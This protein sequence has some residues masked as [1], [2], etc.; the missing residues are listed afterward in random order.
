MIGNK[1]YIFGGQKEDGSLCS[2]DV[3]AVALPSDQPEYTEYA[4][5]PAVDVK[6]PIRTDHAACALN[7]S[8]VVNGGQN[9]Q[10][11]ALDEELGIWLWDRETAKWSRVNADGKTPESRYSHWIFPG[12][13][14]D[15]LILHGGIVNRKPATD[16]W[17]FDFKTCTWT[18]LPSGPAPAIAAQF[19]N[20][21]V[22]TISA[23]SDIN[24]TVNYLDLSKSG[25]TGPE[26]S[27]TEF[28]THPPTS[29]PRPRVGSALVPVTTG[30]GRRYLLY[31]LGS[32][33]DVKIALS[34]KAFTE[35]H[36]FY[37]D[38]WSL[39]IPS[40]SHSASS[41]KDV[42]RDHL[43]GTGSGAFSWAEV[44]IAPV[45]PMQS[46]GKVHPGPRGFFGADACPDGKGAIIWGGI[47]A[48][49]DTEAD[50]WLL[51][52]R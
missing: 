31:L 33:Q 10:G 9:G 35:D 27:S 49:G 44:E 2:S 38:I 45:E 29:G 46:E 6:P 42:I 25:H 50:G 4:C 13:K 47:N 40:N 22:F 34:D 52:V 12:D 39:Q 3:H 1:A 14:K 17:L 18:E 41:V 20:D 8:L 16:T 23:D 24:D 30:L 37:S 15:S 5:Y 51:R 26:W 21:T 43:P 19:V 7:D 32:R 11:K 36:P 48:K 28:P